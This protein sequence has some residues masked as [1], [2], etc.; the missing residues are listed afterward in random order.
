MALLPVFI[1][2]RAM[3]ELFTRE[4]ML[5]IFWLVLIVAIVWTVFRI[6]R[7]LIL[8]VVGNRLNEQVRYILKKAIDYAGAVVIVLTVFDRLGID[9]S[10]ILGAAGIAGVALGFAAQTSVSNVISGLFVM[11][12]RAFKIG[13]V[14][15]VDTTVGVVESFDLLSVRLRTFD[16]QLVRIPNETIIKTNLVNITHYD[17]RRCDLR[18]GVAYGT[19]LRKLKAVLESVALNNEFSVEDPAP[20][21]VFEAF[22]SSSI[23]VMCGVWGPKDKYRDLKNSMMMDISERFAAEGITIPFP[24]LD[25]RFHPDAESSPDA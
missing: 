4:R 16:N 14:L 18:V 22:S 21:V 24:Q 25:V 10:A 6:L 13:D 15:K 12:E 11:T 7:S 9:F 23:D 8:R 1:Y 20:V 19:D 3:N 17:V 5:D 2:S